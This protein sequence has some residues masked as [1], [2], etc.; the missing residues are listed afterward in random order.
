MSA[1]SGQPLMH[2]ELKMS[3]IDQYEAKPHW[4]EAQLWRMHHSRLGIKM[5]HVGR[6][7][8]PASDRAWRSERLGHA[9]NVSE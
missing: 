9:K 8:I 6:Y 4:E 2:E 5:R 1:F 7:G 3:Q